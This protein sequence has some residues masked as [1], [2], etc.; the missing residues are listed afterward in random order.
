MSIDSVTGRDNHRNARRSIVDF[1]GVRRRHLHGVLADGFGQNAPLLTYNTTTGDV[2]TS[3]T[4]SANSTLLI[5]NYFLGGSSIHSINAANPTSP[6]DMQLIS[7]ITGGGS[8]GSGGLFGEFSYGLGVAPSGTIF[9]ATT[10]PGPNSSAI[11]AVDPTTGNRA[12][13]SDATHGRGANHRVRERTRRRARAYDARARARRTG[14]AR[15]ATGAGRHNCEPLRPDLA[16]AR[17][18]KASLIGAPSR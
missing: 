7:G 15:V 9:N 8:R 18:G 2:I 16:C 17:R 14:V 12:V 11:W 10:Q 1:G 4:L 5:G 13:L 6:Y 3:I